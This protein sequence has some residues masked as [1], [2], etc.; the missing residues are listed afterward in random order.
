MRGR[1]LRYAIAVL[2]AALVVALS[3]IMT[4]CGGSATNSAGSDESIRVGAIV[5]LTGT[6]A[7][8]GEAEKNALIL[9][10]ERINAAG[11]VGGRPLEIIIEDDGTDEARAV[12]AAQKLVN[13]DEVVAIIGGSGT[14]STMAIRQVV[15]EA[16][17]P[18]ISMAGGSVVTQEFSPNVYQTPWHNS[19]IIDVLLAHL[20]SEGLTSIAL[21]TD[22][23]SYGKD[24]RTVAL[25]QADSHGITIEVD[26]TFNPG[27]TD[28]TGQVQQVLRNQDVQA[29]VLWNAGKEAPLFIKAAQLAGIDVPM[30]GG[31][32]QA[33]SEFLDGA[34]DSA[35][36]YR[37][38]TGRSFA[39][40]WEA[41]SELYAAN[42]DFASRYE[43]KW[44]HRP[45]IF[46]GHAHDAVTL[47]V[48][49]CARAGESIDGPSLIAALDLTQNVT[50]YAGTFTFSDSDHNG[51]SED[52]VV[53]L[54][55]R[56]G[57]FV[58]VE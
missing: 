31:S 15:E 21:V 30:F 10:Q 55:V 2:I 52:D 50:G 34:G 5:S 46:A 1:I 35:E 13:S 36:G 57:Q 28:M 23:G 45:D 4:G 33:R 7:A 39:M 49:A 27:D 38:V 12:T 54:E 58:T 40:A 42:Q 47:L 11:G 6:Y 48:D 53:L 18:Q 17:I 44:G 16:G 9:E 43:T 29:V 19:L 3:A 26:L 8:L 14:G 37:I 24:G 25:E 32:G 41:D 20:E 51:L 56:D 22:A